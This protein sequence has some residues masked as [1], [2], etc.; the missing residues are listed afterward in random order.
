MSRTYCLRGVLISLLLHAAACDSTLAPSPGGRVVID[1]APLT[2]PGITDA[3]Y[4]L[5]VN[6]PAGT[7][8]SRSVSSTAYGDGSGAV[9]YVG[10]CD[11]DANPNTITLEL[12]GLADAGGPLDPGVDFANPAPA[13]APIELRAD[14]EADADV[15]VRFDLTVARAARQGFFDVAIAF[16]D[17]FCSAKLDCLGSSGTPL[18][19]LF[20]PHS[21]QRDTTA[22][23]AFACTGG[24]GATTQL[25]L[26]P[27]VITCAGGAVFQV[28]PAGG[29]GNLNPPFPGPPNTSDLLF[30]AA[31]YRGTE[32]IGNGATSWGKAYWNLALGLNDAAFTGLGACTLTTAA[33]ASPEPLADQTTPAGVRWPAVT[34]TVPLTDGAGALVCTRHE[35]D[36]PGSGVATAYATERV[37]GACWDSGCTDGIKNGDETDVDCGG[38]CLPCAPGFECLV[39]GDCQTLL[40]AGGICTEATCD[41]GEANGDETGVDC[42]G[43]CPTECLT[44]DTLY[45]VITAA[46]TLTTGTHTFVVHDLPL[47]VEYYAFPATT[48]TTSTALG[49]TT[50]DTRTVIARYD[51]DL[52]IDAGATLTTATRK[53]GLVLWVRGHLTIA[54]AV[55][56]TDRGA[57]AAGK[58]VWLYRNP[59][60][61]V[62][63][64]PAGGGAGGARVGSSNN[65]LDGFAGAAGTASAGGGGSGAAHCN[66]CVAYSGAGAAGTSWSGGPGGGGISRII[67]GGNASG[68]Q[69]NGGAGGVASA[70]QDSGGY[71]KA[72]GGG[73]GNPGGAGKA[74][75][76]GAGY[77]GDGGTGG[78]IIIFAEDGVSLSG[79]LT[80]EGSPGGQVTSG[81]TQWNAGGGGSGGG[82]IYL[83]YGG[84]FDF[85]GSVSAAGGAGGQGSCHL[86]PCLLGGAG[87]D[88]YVSLEPFTPCT[89]CGR[90][91]VPA[92]CE[93]GICSFGYC[94]ASSCSDGV[95]NGDETCVDAGGSCPTPCPAGDTFYDAISSVPDAPNGNWN[96]RVGSTLFPVEAL[97]YGPTTIGGNTS[98]GSGTVDSRS[99]LVRYD[100]DLTINSG[101]LT[102]TT[103]KRGLFLWVRGDL[104]VHGAISMSARGAIA[105]GQNLAI[106]R[107][108]DTS[109]FTI[110][111]A[112]AGG[113]ASRGGYGTSYNG[114]GGAAGT[115]GRSGG[116]GS[117]GQHSNS[118]T[119]YSGAGA[120]GT[121]WSGGAGGGGVS[122]LGSN[123]NAAGGTSN[124]GAG[125]WASAYQTGGV[126][127]KYAGGGAGNNGGAG[128]GA[129]GYVGGNGTGGLLVVFVEGDVL[130]DGS[131]SARG[132]NGGGTN[133]GGTAW[134]AGGGASGGGSVN[135]L[136][137]GTL[138][139]TGSLTAAG[140]TGGAGHCHGAVCQSGGNGGAGSVTVAPLP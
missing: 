98:L 23:L 136:Y 4:L 43:S 82:P 47:D 62:V 132:S 45:D 24:A 116:G 64:L 71:G 50:P 60:D 138:T 12:T 135:L 35:L 38:S 55:S 129:G 51:G 112:G 109:V 11:A 100:G 93:S 106:Y 110:P 61:S 20:H 122:R 91:A 96:L 125:G 2:L 56:M 26:D 134:N 101:T 118:C 131:L 63:V 7:V 78:L 84:A 139:N 9:S 133:A 44:G 124:G 105:A 88:G 41:D 120:A 5:T 70:Y 69:A 29:P 52:T 58:T 30:Q 14:C 92:D 97:S 80:S 49:S 74:S 10:T 102:A 22:V 140:G 8:W 87:G 117:G 31:A 19:L 37:F 95:Q 32:L 113:G 85:T 40:C 86:S 114:A 54:G 72:A 115:G 53:K 111:A 76:M 39:P 73:A 3:T 108:A 107:R 81:P 25:C 79:A 119:T 94:V 128:A 17:I 99:L 130:I 126:Y 1:V 36:A 48:L 75:Q 89:G 67:Y 18:E 65:S 34:W 77:S 57:K 21:G 33:T 46:P 123:G 104:T 121:S 6:S 42:G 66:T 15:A 137:R 28:D 83:F 27:L 59:D 13:G 16:D 103:R 68:G 127:F 90:C